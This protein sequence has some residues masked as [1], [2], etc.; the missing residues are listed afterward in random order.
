MPGARQQVRPCREDTAGQQVAGGARL[1][2]VGA[3]TRAP[4]DHQV[5]RCAGVSTC[6][7]RQPAG[8][9]VGTPA[10]ASVPS[11]SARAR[12]SGQT[13]AS[14]VPRI[15]EVGTKPPPGVLT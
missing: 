6:S 9:T 12:A 15:S 5:A 13:T 3:Q 4:R 11:G 1:P 8:T 10:N 2:E 7:G 14:T